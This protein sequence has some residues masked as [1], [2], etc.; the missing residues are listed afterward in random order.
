MRRGGDGDEGGG[1]GGG[2]AGTHG[3]V[4]RVGAG[5]GEGSSDEG[6][7]KWAGAMLMPIGPL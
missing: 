7:C 6:W 2:R 5:R 4:V 1:R 3:E